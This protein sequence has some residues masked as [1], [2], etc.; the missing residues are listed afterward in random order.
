MALPQIV[1]RPGKDKALRK[2]YPWVFANQVDRKSDRPERGAVVRIVSP[3]GEAFGLGLYHDESLIAARFLTTD[4]EAEIGPAF[5]RERVRRA[6][7]LRRAAFPEATHARIAFGESDGLPGTVVDRYG[8]PGYARGVLT[9]TC[10]SYGMEGPERLSSTRSRTSRPGRHRG[11]ERRPAP[12][13][14]RPAER[15]PA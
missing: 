8:P 5:F 15:P 14:G 13:E 12:P 1:L 10:L 7:A 3:Q 2:G 4:V 11:A 9:W 6:V